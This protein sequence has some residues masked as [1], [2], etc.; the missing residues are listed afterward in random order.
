MIPSCLILILLNFLFGVYLLTYLELKSIE[1]IC[2]T[3]K[4]IKLEKYQ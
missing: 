1:S 4:T 2:F 3:L